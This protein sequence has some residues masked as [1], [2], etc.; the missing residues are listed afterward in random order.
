VS[1][2]QPLTRG[3][4]EGLESP[5]PP[6]DA[7][8]AGAG[9]GKELG[10]L[11]EVSRILDSSLDLRDVVGP[12][13][14]TVAAHLGFRR[15]F[16]TLHNR[17]TGEIA[18]ESAHGLS[19]TQRRKGIYRLGEG[20]TGRVVQS[21]E[22]AIVERV[23]EEPQFL[24]RTGGLESGRETSY[25]CVPIKLGNA[26]IGALSGAQDHGSASALGEKARV[27]TVIASMI[28]QAVKLRQAA[29]EEQR[30]LLE[31]NT[32]LQR[33]LRTRF[34]PANIIGNARSMLEV[35]DLV[36]QVSKSD[37]TVLLRGESGTGKELVAHAIHYNSL[38]AEKPFIKVNLAALPE[39]VMES[40]LFGHEK[41]AFTGA[42]SA[43]KGRFELASGG[44]IFLDEIGD[45][46]PATQ[47]KLLRV[48]QEREFE[49]VGGMSTIRSDVRVI[50][51]TNRPLEEL[52]TKG[53]FRAD[54]YYRLDVFPIHVPPLRERKA[55]IL[56]LADH[57]VEKYGSRA[58][59]AI[60]RIST[61]AID[62]LV[63]YHWPGNVR[64]L[65]NCIERA[66]LLSADGVIHSHH[67]PP[68]LQTAEASD[69][70]QEGTLG[71]RLEAV[72][73]EYI[74][75]ALKSTR[76]NMAK[77]AGLLGI[78]ERVMGLRVARYGLDPGRFKVRM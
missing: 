6:S 54:L 1:A 22:P 78:T 41:G 68:T 40:E 29:M 35:F 61:P 39:S 44:S 50:A 76:G 58:G 9:D 49:R 34:R 65:E 10:L 4:V 31:E 45:L 72:E 62:M 5:P 71:S 75:E 2:R 20:I 47:V 43:R 53:Q 59:R 55:D 7:D 25:I 15:T 21:G 57:F 70:V 60:R 18:I 17:E 48:L 26:P 74:Q 66:C 46:S 14:T 52:M 27:L 30:R 3:R 36:D 37:T 12:I 38:R 8:R 11:L 23:S 13:L 24:D 77:A 42:T 69:T 19:A 67:L 64:E 63:A 73:R 56:L 51:A 33:E 28:A 16:L 32:R